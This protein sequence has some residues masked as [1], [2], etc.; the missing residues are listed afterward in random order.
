L[1]EKVK[2]SEKG[3]MF[4]MNDQ[5]SRLQK[6]DMKIQEQLIKEQEIYRVKVANERKK[7]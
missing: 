6:I 4:E 2:E 7:A 3:S 1:K 5:K